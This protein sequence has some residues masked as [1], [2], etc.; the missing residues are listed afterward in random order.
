M[1]YR[2]AHLRHHLHLHL[3]SCCLWIIIFVDLHWS[4]CVELSKDR[5]HLKGIRGID[6]LGGRFWLNVPI[7]RFGSSNAETL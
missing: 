3:R 4:Q 2:D 7:R 5:F 6:F 1:L